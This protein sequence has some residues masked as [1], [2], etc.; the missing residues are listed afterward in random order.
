MLPAA[1]SERQHAVAPDRGGV[2]TT[3]DFA[4]RGSEMKYYIVFLTMCS[5]QLTAMV[6]N[7]TFHSSV[8][9]DDY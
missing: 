2:S 8:Y 3:S 9:K 7:S 5:A 6:P 4:E 1:V